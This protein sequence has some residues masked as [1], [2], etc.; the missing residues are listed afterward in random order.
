MN[1]VTRHRQPSQLPS[2]VF[3]V[4]LEMEPAEVSRSNWQTCPRADQEMGGVFS[5][6]RGAPRGPV[7]FITD[8]DI[9][10]LL[11]T[12]SWIFPG[13][14]P[15]AKLQLRQNIPS[16]SLWTVPRG[17]AQLFQCSLGGG[18][19]A[20]ATSL[21]AAWNFPACRRS[22][23]AQLMRPYQGRAPSSERTDWSCR[24]GLSARAA[25]YPSPGPA[26]ATVLHATRSL[27]V[28]EIDR[29]AGTISQELV[30]SRTRS[31][32]MAGP[33][34]NDPA[35]RGARHAVL[36]APAADHPQAGQW[37]ASTLKDAASA[38]IAA[39]HHLSWVG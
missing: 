9:V 39:L 1:A 19:T 5:D 25:R 12:G 15:S 26:R 14:A 24:P 23:V 22:Q 38:S 35:G 10:H 20:G 34:Y 3:E 7:Q 8:E 13:L 2:A 16:R 6:A 29:P 37:P 33:H 27:M 30:L 18:R 11:H 21:D 36:P 32:D 31:R 4:K 17:T 28:V